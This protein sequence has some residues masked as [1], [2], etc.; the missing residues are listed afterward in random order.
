MLGGGEFYCGGIFWARPVDHADVLVRVADPVDVEKARCD[1]RARAGRGRGRTFAEQFHIEAALF[2]RF[3]ERGLLR[4]FIQ[5][6]VAAE[7]Q[8]FV[9][10]A[11]V[12]E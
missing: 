4:V 2:L 11:M 9:Q 8:P 7:R 10:L 1:E 6:N 3:A 5:F 12:D